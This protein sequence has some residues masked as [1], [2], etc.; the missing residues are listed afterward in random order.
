MIAKMGMVYESAKVHLNTT[1]RFNAAR[2][3]DAKALCFYFGVYSRVR[4]APSVII[5]LG[6]CLL[7]RVSE[8]VHAN[9]VACCVR[10]GALKL[11]RVGVGW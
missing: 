5:P 11:V 7:R 10:R 6:N 1:H 3:V 4:S 8:R 2:S 9:Y